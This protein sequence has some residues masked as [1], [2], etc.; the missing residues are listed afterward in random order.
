MAQHAEQIFVG[1]KNAA[2]SEQTEP[3]RELKDMLMVKKPY[4][5]KDEADQVLHLITCMLQPSPEHRISAREL[6]A[7]PW[8]QQ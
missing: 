1:F 3:R 5:E 2:P 4:I 8:L 7:H 6:T